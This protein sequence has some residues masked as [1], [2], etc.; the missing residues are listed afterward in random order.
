MRDDLLFAPIIGDGDQTALLMDGGGAVEGG[1]YID[2]SG[3][4][5]SGEIAAAL[6]GLGAEAQRAL[7]ELGLGDWLAVVCESRDA[8]FALAPAPG[9]RTV[10]VA[11][12]PAVPVGYVRRLLTK[13]QTHVGRR[14][15][16]R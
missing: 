8:T 1:L 13:A 5:V 3:A 9:G 2:S 12:D 10:L 6:A 11:A 4:D 16:G 14:E 7:K 15:P